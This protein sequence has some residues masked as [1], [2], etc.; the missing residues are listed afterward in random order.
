MFAQKIKFSLH[1]LVLIHLFLSIIFISNSFAQENKVRQFE[2]YLIDYVTNKRVPS[3]SAGVLRD[4]KIVWLG[5]KGKI[6][7]ENNVF[8]F[9]SLAMRCV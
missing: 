5:V 3:I 4:G 8:A 9:G 6:D 2:N 7:L 1:I